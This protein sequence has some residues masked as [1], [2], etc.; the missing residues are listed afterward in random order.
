MSDEAPQAQQAAP[1]AATAELP[2]IRGRSTVSG[3][4]W[5]TAQT[6]RHT[7]MK[8]K[9]LRQGWSKQLEA[10]KQRQIVLAIQTELRAATA[11]KKQQKK[12]A[13]RARQEQKRENEKKGEVV[14]TVSASKVKRMKK[15]QLRNIRKVGSD[16]EAAAAGGVGAKGKKA[17]K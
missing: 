2:P 12:D 3:K 10:R 7:A 8:P 13:E 16:K 6:T 4:V 17:R 1:A 14:Q 9:S 15:N 5:K 11:A